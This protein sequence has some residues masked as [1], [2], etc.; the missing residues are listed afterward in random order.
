VWNNLDNGNTY[1]PSYFIKSQNKL[2]D[3][4]VK[5]LDISAIEIRKNH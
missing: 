2:N 3:T 1:L 5:S 4:I